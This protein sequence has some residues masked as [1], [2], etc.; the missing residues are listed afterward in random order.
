MEFLILMAYSD[1]YTLGNLCEGINRS[2]AEQYSH[3]FLSVIRPCEEIFALIHP[4]KHVTWFKIYLLLDILQREMARMS[5]SATN[6]IK[7]LF[8]IDGDAIIINFDITLN[9]MISQG[10]GKELIIAE[11]I[12]PSC[13]INAG[14]FF[15]KVCPW[16][17]EFLTEVW[18]LSKYDDV[19]YYEQSSMI[20]I[21]RKQKEKLRCMGPFHSYLKNGPQSVKFFPHVAVF[22]LHLFSSNRCISYREALHLLQEIQEDDENDDEEDTGE[23]EKLFDQK[24]QNLFVFHAAG[25]RHKL[26]ILKAIILKYQLPCSIE[27]GSE[28]WNHLT[29]RLNRNHL[30]HYRDVSSSSSS[31]S[32]SVKTTAIVTTTDTIVTATIT[33]TMTDIQSPTEKTNEDR[34]VAVSKTLVQEET[35]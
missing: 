2:Y 9:D 25:T 5:E 20:K 12:H 3:E 27:I 16:S 22:P 34:E 11:D 8:W 29:F 21:L 13:P 7:Y 19:F 26:K 30:G 24:H 6:T 4:K 31:S 18:N 23:E 35:R 33:T 28:E 14:V 32:S 10:G 15:L 17:L 1:D